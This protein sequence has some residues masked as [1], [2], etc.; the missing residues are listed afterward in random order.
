MADRMIKTVIN[1][2]LLAGYFSFT[3]IHFAEAA[4]TPGGESACVPGKPA[5]E[6]IQSCTKLISLPDI[7]GQARRTALMIRG[8]TYSS[9]NETN[10][11]IADYVDAQKIG[12]SVDV[13]IGLG[14]LYINS[15]KSDEAIIEFSKIIDTGNGN[16]NIFNY[17]GMAFENAG[18]YEEAISDFNKSLLLAPNLL[19]ALN[20]RAAAYAKQGNWDA[21]VKDIDSVLTKNPDMPVALVNRCA[22]QER[23]GK[24]DLGLQSC[25]KAEQLDPANYFIL[26]NIGFI[27]YEVGRFKEAIAYFDRSL[28]LLPNDAKTLYGRGKAEEKLGQA[29]ESEADI[30]AAERIQPDVAAFLATGGFK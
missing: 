23:A 13:A 14:G 9:L 21:A 17:R 11:A 29:A 12:Y 19:G 10:L 25:N 18:K 3:D 15:G 8:N 30:A 6:I 16:A 20:N 27:Y 2:I 4:N 26:S 24:V 22:F 5:N 1:T 28:K 7:D